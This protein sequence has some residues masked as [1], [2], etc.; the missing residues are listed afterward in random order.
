VLIA[1]ITGITIALAVWLAI[2]SVAQQRVMSVHGRDPVSRDVLASAWSRRRRT[3]PSL[4]ERLAA[5][6]RTLSS[7]LRAGTTPSEALARAAG[8][9]P[10]WPNALAASRFGEPVDAGFMADAERNPELAMSLR[11]LAACWHVGVTRG[12]GLAVS[13]ERLALSL[14]TQQE[15]QSTLRNELAA[16]RA[17]GRM[18]TF[19]PV[20]GVA[21]GYLLG[22]DPI[23]WFLGSSVG[24]LVF[25]IALALTIA[26]TVWTRR[27]VHRVERGLV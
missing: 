25:A 19:L 23:A 2:P 18:L 12:S 20:V 3:G 14:R 9:P 16:P 27:I 1:S 10:L 21:M 4:P 5:A 22:A 7:E 6:L 17:T 15:L 11:Q 8:E 13:V 26:G 24:A